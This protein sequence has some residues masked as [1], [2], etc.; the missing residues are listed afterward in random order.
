MLRRNQKFINS[1]STDEICSLTDRKKNIITV[2]V[3]VLAK[4]SIS[5]YEETCSQYRQQERHCGKMYSSFSPHDQMKLP[6]RNDRQFNE[7]K[8]ANE[9]CIST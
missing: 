4:K 5:V 8:N 9:L 2:K 6:S 7:L 3:H 1:L